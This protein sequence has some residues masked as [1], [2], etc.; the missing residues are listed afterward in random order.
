MTFKTAKAI[1]S[2]VSQKPFPFSPLPQ[3]VAFPLVLKFSAAPSGKG[4]GM[5][6]E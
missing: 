1:Q 6:R 2:G 5:L 3:Q 4:P